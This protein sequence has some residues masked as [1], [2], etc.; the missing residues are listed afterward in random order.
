MFV[1]YSYIFFGLSSSNQTP[2]W[3]R[4]A[5]S[6][7]ASAPNASSCYHEAVHGWILMLLA[8][9]DRF[10]HGRITVVGGEDEDGPMD[11]VEVRIDPIS[12]PCVARSV[13]LSLFLYC[14]FC[15]SPSARSGIEMATD[16]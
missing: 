4:I 11:D 14:S 12:R 2:P 6:L 13:S 1:R 10:L 8:I 9:V 3:G 16:P 5:M 15:S 7:E